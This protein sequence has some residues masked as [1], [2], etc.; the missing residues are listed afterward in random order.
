MI[1]EERKIA[2]ELTSKAIKSLIKELEIRGRDFVTTAELRKY[3]HN[4][5]TD[6][7]I[8]KVYRGKVDV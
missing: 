4:M 3:I 6:T 5:E 7:R 1:T 8:G 2:I